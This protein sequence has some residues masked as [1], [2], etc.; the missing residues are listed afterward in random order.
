MFLLFIQIKK[1][2]T[3][4]YCHQLEEES[5]L[6]DEDIEEDKTEYDEP[7]KEDKIPAAAKIREDTATLED[8]EVTKIRMVKTT[9]FQRGKCVAAMM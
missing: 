6:G 7:E 3:K 5:G 2:C 9:R 8:A 4:L 1:I